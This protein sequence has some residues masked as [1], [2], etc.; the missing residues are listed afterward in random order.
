[1]F[2]TGCGKEIRNDASFCANCGTATAAASDHESNIAPTKTDAS[3]ETD[4]EKSKPTMKEKAVFYCIFCALMLIVYLPIRM[5]IS[6]NISEWYR[7]I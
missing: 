4:A 1:M 5:V 7:I 6:D 3:P 2:C